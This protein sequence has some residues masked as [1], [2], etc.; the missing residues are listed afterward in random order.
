MGME[1]RSNGFWILWGLLISWALHYSPHLL[2]LSP[3][4]LPPSFVQ[5]YSHAL[6]PI[7]RSENAAKTQPC[8]QTL[9]QLHS[10]SIEKSG[11]QSGAACWPLSLVVSPGLFLTCG[12]WWLFPICLPQIHPLFTLFYTKKLTPVE[13]LTYTPLPNDFQLD[14]NDGRHWQEVESSSKKRWGTYLLPWCTL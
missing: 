9:G 2:S 10:W 5:P 4:I 8:S 13:C 6:D 12:L 1:A 3:S 7:L 14:L 11:S